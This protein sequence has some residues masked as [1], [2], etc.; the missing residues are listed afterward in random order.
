MISKNNPV[1]PVTALK[2][3]L[4]EK[5][6]KGH[7][8]RLTMP[9]G[10]YNEDFKELIEGVMEIPEKNIRK[11]EDSITFEYN[12]K[13]KM[14]K[15]SNKRKMAVPIRPQRKIIEDKM[16]VVPVPVSELLEASKK[17]LKDATG[18]EIDTDAV[19]IIKEIGRG[20]GVLMGV[21]D[22]TGY[23]PIDAYIKKNKVIGR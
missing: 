17:M 8:F 4:L 14:F 9:E 1:G 2:L 23:S 12:P 16:G 15:E 7:G 10:T 21:R 18:K 5:F 6:K 20:F 11:D 3:T 22:K 19:P 13:N